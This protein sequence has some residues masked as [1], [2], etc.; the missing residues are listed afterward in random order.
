MDFANL[1]RAGCVPDNF[2]LRLRGDLTTGSREFTMTDD[3]VYFPISIKI[4]LTTGV[5]GSGRT[6]ILNLEYRNHTIY[7]VSCTA[8]QAPS[9]TDEYYFAIGSPNRT[10]TFSSSNDLHNAMI[11]EMMIIK[12]TI[13]K[14]NV[15][16]GIAGDEIIRASMYALKYQGNLTKFRKSLNTDFKIIERF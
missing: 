10:V 1:I 12:D 16:N 6:P 3:V 9:L 8:T 13:F 14:I 11:P 7:K 4:S 2:P 15:H 5:G